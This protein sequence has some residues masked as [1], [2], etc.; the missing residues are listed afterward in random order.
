MK[1]IHCFTIAYKNNKKL[2]TPLVVFW[3]GFGKYINK[4]GNPLKAKVPKSH[5]F[6]YFYFQS[7]AKPAWIPIYYHFISQL[8]FTK[9]KSLDTLCY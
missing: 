6:Q 2:F 9:T 7:F 3:H 8:S 1:L 4:S 5:L